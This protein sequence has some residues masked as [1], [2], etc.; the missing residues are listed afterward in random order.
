VNLNYLGDA[1]FTT[2]ALAALRARYPHAAVDVLAG[3]RA[4]AMLAGN[5]SA[6]RVIVR[7][8]RHGSARAT[9]FAQTIRE[10][11]Y[12]AAVLFQSITSNAAL[13]WLLRVPVRV[14]FAQDGCTPFLTHRVAGRRDGEHVVDAYLRLALAAPLEKT[15]LS[16]PSPALSIAISDEDRGFAEQVFRNRELMPPVVGLVIGATRPQKR[17]PEEYWVRLADKLWSSGNISSVLLGGPEEMEA[18]QRILSQAKKAPLA[19]LVGRTSEKQ[20]AAV[21][22]RLGLVIS[23]DSGPLHIAT[24]MQ[25]PVVALFGS[26][27]PAE[28]GP[29]EG[30][31]R[32]A[33]SS[34]TTVLYD[35]LDC[36]P[37][38]KNPTCNGRF[39]C[40]RLL[41][42]ERVF[43]AA[44]DLLALPAS[45]RPL[46][47]I[48]P[49]GT[50][51]SPRTPAPVAAAAGRSSRALPGESR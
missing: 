36:A 33:V 34:T 8:R 19:S 20:L 12:D 48:P 16:I 17:W 49:V 38:R 28:T 25:T 7:P 5:P 3:E 40:L 1:L 47:M 42:P 43:E 29:W 23:G 21:I 45:R 31:S 24:A 13:S 2:P 39:D 44:A 11:H 22:E 14:G 37:C 26:T 51:A 18:A 35:S 10:G 6:D 30:A 4:A 41:T 50:A 46:P 15:S 27:D 9:A 32:S